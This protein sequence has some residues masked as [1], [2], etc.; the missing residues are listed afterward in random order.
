MEINVRILLYPICSYFPQA[1]WTSDALFIPGT[2]R[3][4]Q[5]LLEPAVRC[6]HFIRHNEHVYFPME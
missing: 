3:L 4:T 1:Q 5:P 2:W 6:D